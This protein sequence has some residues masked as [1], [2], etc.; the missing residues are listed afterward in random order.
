MLEKVSMQRTQQFSDFSLQPKECVVSK[1]TKCRI[2]LSEI[3]LFL[4]NH[5]LE[6]HEINWS[7]ERKLK[8]LTEEISDISVNLQQGIGKDLFVRL[9][10]LTFEHI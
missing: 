8:T 3:R 2:A 5:S 4:K 7:I 10:L 9:L 6:F 1:H